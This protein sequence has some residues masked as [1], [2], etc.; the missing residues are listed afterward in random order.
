MQR[1]FRVRN[2]SSS[3]DEKVNQFL[4]IQGKVVSVTACKPIDDQQEI[5]C[6]LVVA[7]DGKEYREVQEVKNPLD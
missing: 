4:G 7:D 2:N 1:L 3:D 5:G 6:W